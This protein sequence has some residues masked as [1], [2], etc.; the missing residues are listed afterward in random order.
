MHGGSYHACFYAHLANGDAEV[1]LAESG[2]RTRNF[3]AKIGV[4][5][6]SGRDL[7]P[8]EKFVFPVTQEKT[9]ATSFILRK[10]AEWCETILVEREIES[11]LNLAVYARQRN[12]SRLNRRSGALLTV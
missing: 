3:C 12:S 10:V 5:I 2:D 6:G 4:P 8:I 7:Q 1:E 11:P 9:S